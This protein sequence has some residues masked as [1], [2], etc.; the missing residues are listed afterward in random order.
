MNIT[1]VLRANWKLVSGFCGVVTL[2]WIGMACAPCAGA[3]AQKATG[4]KAPARPKLVV[5]LVV[6]QMRGDY[7]DKLQGQWTGGL[8]RLVEEG[9]GST[10]R[11]IPMPR[12]RPVWDTRRFQQAPFRQCTEWFRMRGG[13]GSSR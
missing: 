6:D 4:T 13:T 11:R 12:R 7:V 1:K 2:L 8:K 9:G 3:Q 5:M 10:M